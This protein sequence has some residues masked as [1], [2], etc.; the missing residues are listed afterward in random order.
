[1]LVVFSHAMVL[2]LKKYYFSKL[3]KPSNNKLKLDDYIQKNNTH[4]HYQSSS[5]QQNFLK[6]QKI[7]NNGNVF[8]DY[9]LTNNKQTRIIPNYEREKSQ[10]AK[11][12]SS[13]GELQIRKKNVPKERP[14]SFHEDYKDYEQFYQYYNYKNQHR[15]SNNQNNFKRID[16]PKRYSAIR[17]N[18]QREHNNNKNN[19]NGNSN[20]NTEKSKVE[21]NQ[22]NRGKQHSINKITTKNPFQNQ[23]ILIKQ[24]LVTFSDAPIYH[25]DYK[26]SHTSRQL[27]HCYQPP[28]VG[29]NQQFSNYYT[30]QISFKIPS[31]SDATQFYNIGYTPID[32]YSTTSLAGIHNQ[33]PIFYPPS[34]NTIVPQIQK[35]QIQPRQSKAIPI[36]NPEVNSF[37]NTSFMKFSLKKNKHL[38]QQK[39]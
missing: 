1:M 11:D 22:P 36:I 30:Q 39:I 13:P 26:L 34:N 10:S 37:T 8:D 23:A 20:S 4:N 14:K 17:T 5:Y 6:K 28:I 27:L 2:R 18:Q 21:Q 7:P 16:E 29:L 31:P 12:L 35:T 25:S 24:P 15:Y 9:L 38:R 3:S 19:E 32:Q 33:S